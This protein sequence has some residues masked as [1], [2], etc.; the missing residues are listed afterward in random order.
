[1]WVFGYGSLTWDGWEVSLGCTRKTV[2]DLPGFCRRFNKAS[3]KNWGSKSA[4]G[5]TLNLVKVAGHLCRGIAF[6][7]P[8]DHGESIREYLEIREGNSFPLV[9]VE[10][11]LNDG[12]CT[13]AVVPIYTGKQ[14]IEGRT[15]HELASMVRA[16]SGTHGRCLDYVEGV[17]TKLSEM[18]IDDP[19]V[20][21]LWKTISETRF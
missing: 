2:A 10:V 17:A 13:P 7:F 9:Q 6:E 1:M 8:D 21:E 4:P 12:V 11:R 3:T 15:L 19:A 20:A 14:L 5:P 18:G 16:A